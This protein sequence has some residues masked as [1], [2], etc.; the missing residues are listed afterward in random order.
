MKGEQAYIGGDLPSESP[1]QR[2]LRS[3]PPLLKADKFDSNRGEQQRA[4]VG[5]VSPL[6]YRFARAEREAALPP[7]PLRG[8]H[9]VD[10]PQMGGWS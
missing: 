10:P 8:K 4:P 9:E 5:D 1:L 7:R 6:K 2:S 3:L